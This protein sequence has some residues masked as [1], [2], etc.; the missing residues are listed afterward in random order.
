MGIRNW[1]IIYLLKDKR[2]LG[3]ALLITLLVLFLL[4]FLQVLP[5]GLTNFL[6]WF[7]LLTPLTTFFYLLY[8]FLF[9]ITASLF[10]WRL[11][12]RQ[13]VCPAGFPG[14]LSAFFGGLTSSCTGCLSLVALIL[15]FSV[16]LL[17][18]R[19]NTEIMILSIIFLLISLWLLGAF[20]KANNN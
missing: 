10:L 5:Q 7:S 3:L 16:A 20:Q 11:K 14:T 2:Y 6:F 13:K 8:G 18:N 12:R 9:G 4:P 19:Y 17:L 15:P 1:Q